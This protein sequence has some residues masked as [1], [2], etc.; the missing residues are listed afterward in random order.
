MKKDRLSYVAGYWLQHGISPPERRGG[1]RR[2]ASSKPQKEAIRKHIEGFQCKARHYARR[3]APGRK[4]LPCDLSV[5]K[6]H[7]MFEDQNHQQVSYGLYYSVF[8]YD[9]NLGFGSPAKDMCG[10]CMQLKMKQRDPSLS[11]EERRN[12]LGQLI[13]HKQVA[14]K[15]Y[16]ELNSVGKSL[17]VCFDVM[18]N[19]VLPKTSVGQAFYSRQLYMYV[20]GIVVHRGEGQGQAKDDVNLYWWTENQN[21]KDSSMIASALLHCLKSAVGPEPETLEHLRLFSDG[22]YGQNK[23]ISVISMLFSLRKSL[24]CNTRIEYF[25]PVRGHSFLPA[26]RVFGRLEQ[27]IRKQDPILHPSE[28]VD[29]MSKHGKTYEYG[30]DFISYDFKSEAL[31][32]CKQARAFKLSEAK[33]CEING[34]TL[35]VKTSYYGEFTYHSLLKRGRKWSTYCPSLEKWSTA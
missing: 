27:S 5:K 4:Y 26:D 12:V 28:Y 9:F 30:K 2:S 23:N 19:L 8:V 22:C 6:M 20:F 21:R 33:V 25:F 14:Q 11:L 18:E 13:S 32:H 34:D 15:F 10:T 1:D 24:L 17:T 31:K 3:G 16:R 7:E 29:I 35:G